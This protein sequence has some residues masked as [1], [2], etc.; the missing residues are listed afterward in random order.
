MCGEN[1][2][3]Q[4]VDVR[5]FT[6]HSSSSRLGLIDSNIV[7]NIR[8]LC[9]LPPIW[10]TIH[11]N[12]SFSTFLRTCSRNISLSNEFCC[13]SYIIYH[14]RPLACVII[15]DEIPLEIYKTKQAK[16]EK[17]NNHS[18][19]ANDLSTNENSHSPPSSSLYQFF[20]LS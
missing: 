20:L 10:F 11:H 5:L 17:S 19:Y 7:T 9:S 1:V 12:S 8:L 15:N 14:R 3:R 13:L 4:L 18:T 16:W 2:G 6:F